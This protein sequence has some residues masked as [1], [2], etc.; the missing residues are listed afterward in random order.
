MMGTFEFTLVI[1]KPEMDD[2]KAADYLYTS[3]CD[4]ALFG[5]S[6]GEYTLD[7]ARKALTHVDAVFTAI[8]DVNTSHAGVHVLG[9]REKQCQ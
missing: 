6:N 8:R 1:S 9:V 3:G 2:V 4:D 7:F 5:A